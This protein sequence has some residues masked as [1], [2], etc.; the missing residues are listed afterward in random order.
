MRVFSSIIE[1]QYLGK[2]KWMPAAETLS[3]RHCK[4]KI[5]QAADMP[6]HSCSPTST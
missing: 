5:R 2:S 1:I 3:R 4:N 6:R